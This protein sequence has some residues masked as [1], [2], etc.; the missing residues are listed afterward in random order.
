[1]R[2][3]ATTFEYEY[4]K[5]KFKEGMWGIS[6]LINLYNCNEIIIRDKEKIR[7]FIKSLCK[8]IDMVAYGSPIIEHCG[9]EPHLK[10]FSFLQL[11]TTSS[12]T[13][14]FSEKLNVAYIDIFSCKAFDPIKTV[15]FC[16]NYF[17]AESNTY[18]IEFRP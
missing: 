14:H 7:Q 1:M 12:I 17:E 16:S 18:T 9:I 10:G 4:I 6:C 8:E 5:N 13:G 2:N 15:V 3:S 11:I